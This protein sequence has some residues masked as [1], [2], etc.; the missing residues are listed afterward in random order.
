MTVQA[1]PEGTEGGDIVRS[2]ERLR[3]DQIEALRADLNALRQDVKELISAGLQQAA[4]AA[5][6]R[7]EDLKQRAQ[8]VGDAAQERGREAHRQLA[9]TA[10][11]RPLTT[12]GVAM[13]AGFIV[14]KV[15][16]Y[17]SRD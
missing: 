16:G 5:S 2:T 1:E 8:I 17:A 15:M 7:Y 10:Y 14:G 4:D 9:E 6:S 12:I 3:G 13:L 11:E